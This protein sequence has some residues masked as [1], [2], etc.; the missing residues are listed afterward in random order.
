MVPLKTFSSVER[1]TELIFEV[2]YLSSRGKGRTDVMF[3][4]LNVSK[5]QELAVDREYLFS[6][7]GTLDDLAYS[8]GFS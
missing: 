2:K 5:M 3:T 8:R 6:W 7:V 1:E 4:L